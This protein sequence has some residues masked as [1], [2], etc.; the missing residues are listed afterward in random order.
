M[1]ATRRI[2]VVLPVYNEEESVAIVVSRALEV[3]PQIAGDYEVL[4]VDDGSVDRTAEVVT[5]L[6]DRHYPRVRL[7]THPGNRGY[8]AALRTGFDRSRYELVF[9]TDADNQFDVAELAG[10]MDVLAGH[11]VVVGYRI[12]RHDRRLRRLTSWG[13]NRIV[14]V[15]FRV[16]VRDVDCAFKLFR[17]E[18]L[19]GMTVETTDFFVDTELLAKAR[20]GGA[21]VVEKGV[22]HYP[23][24][25][26]A[27]TVRTSD[28]PRTLSTVFRMW[29]RIYLARP[30]HVAEQAR[31]R[32]SLGEGVAEVT[33]LSR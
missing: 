32:A 26:G 16:R 1:T 29:Q 9:Y 28:I 18:I 19:D 17:R 4:V 5:A 25:S 7:L 24:V 14:R 33:P 22:R 30:R 27:T 2:S 23:R 31:V 15:L 6:V 21:S 20:K 11:D 10:L 3:L 13:Y 12:D 8:G